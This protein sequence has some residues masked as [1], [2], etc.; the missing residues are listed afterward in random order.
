M[1]SDGTDAVAGPAPATASS[2][3]ARPVD[4]R[5]RGLQIR[6]AETPEEVRKAQELRYRVFVEEM[7][8]KPTPAMRA[9][10]R[11]FDA[12]D[13]YCDHLLILEAS[14]TGEERVVATYRFL[15][16]AQALKAGGFYTA[17]EYDISPL[18]TY[19]GEVME[20]GRSCVDPDYRT[21]ANMQLLWRGITE[22]VLHFEVALLFGCASLYATDPASLAVPLSYL[23]HK[24]L[25]PKE[26]RPRA[27]E[28]R[29]VD[30]NLLPPE[31]I[32]EKEALQHL[33]PL[34]KGYLRLGGYVGEGAVVDYEFGTTDVCVVVKTDV[35][36]EKYR[37]HL[38]RQDRANETPA[39]EEAGGEPEE[40]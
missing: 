6:L 1:A 16:R 28:S 23:H 15:R 4:V 39:G 38:T 22:Y 30:M 25:A 14:G 7:S 24:H 31:E 17:T 10:R 37:R 9:E 27:L 34:L 20:L 13:P 18:L 19:P 2:E 11:E 12:F 29:F 5:S 3:G 26:L 40:S 36:T 35:V 21:G 8:A 33:P 32:D